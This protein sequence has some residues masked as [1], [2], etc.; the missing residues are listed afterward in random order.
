[1]EQ[2][3]S[4]SPI[5]CQILKD[6]ARKEMTAQPGI[7]TPNLLH[8]KPVCYH[9]ATAASYEKMLKVGYLIHLKYSQVSTFLSEINKAI[10]DLIYLVVTLVSRCENDEIL[11]LKVLELKLETFLLI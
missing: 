10:S 8:V 6:F 2:L 11:S 3:T 4:R 1:M 7:R 9:S 5:F